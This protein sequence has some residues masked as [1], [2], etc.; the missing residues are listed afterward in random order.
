MLIEALAITF[1]AGFALIAAFGHV[2]LFKD[3]L[4]LGND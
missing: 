2:V 1:I 4:S 3:M